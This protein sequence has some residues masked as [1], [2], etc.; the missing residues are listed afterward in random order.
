[1]E[2]NSGLEP[3]VEGLVL[4]KATEEE[5][6]FLKTGAMLFWRC[7]THLQGDLIGCNQEVVALGDQGWG[8]LAL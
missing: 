1:M 3:L 7:D 8:G 5:C 6:V 4:I 2:L